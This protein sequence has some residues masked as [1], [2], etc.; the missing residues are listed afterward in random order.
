MLFNSFDFLVFFP[1]VVIAYF[2]CPHRRRWILL[3]FASYFFYMCWN[4]AYL[5][6]IVAS[7]AASYL[8][9]RLMADAPPTKRRVLLVAAIV[10]NLGMLFAFKYLGFAFGTLQSMLAVLNVAVRL[11]DLRFLLPI[12]ISFYTFQALSYC[13]DVYRGDMQPEKH[14]GVF[15]VYVSF[16]PQLVA[17][18]IERSTRLLPQFYRKHTFSYDKA[19]SGLRLMLWG[20]FKKMVIADRIAVYVDAVYGNPEAHFG[21]TV[22]IAAYLF[23]YQIYCDFSAYSD[24]AVGAARIMG[25]DLMTN[26]RRPYHASSVRDFW[27]RWHISLSTWFRDYLYVPLGGNRLS[28][29]KW[30]RNIAVVFLL[31]GLWHGAA[32]NFVVWG[33]LHGLYLV[34]WEAAGKRLKSKTDGSGG[35]ISSWWQRSLGVFVTFHLVTF[36][37][38]FFRAETLS[39]AS[40]LIRNLLRWGHTTF[41]QSVCIVPGR[42]WLAEVFCAIVLVE[43]VHL[44]QA[45]KKGS[46]AWVLRW[47]RPVRWAV[48][49]ALVMWIVF[50][51]VVGHSPFIYFQF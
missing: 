9:G 35:A 12:G 33:A 17:G 32:W 26:F 45:L 21:P 29:G 30:V 43:G 31:S 44:L 18:P 8:C 50:L 23:A 51:G 41:A 37:W 27:G 5:V 14:F 13:I 20:F 7:T 3:L 11:P 34:G 10:A 38:I 42:A 2:V 6:L 46:V 25:Y 28:K 36:A 40:L 39:D 16:F 48:Y 22:A 24:I 1:A 19:T 4:P 15:A 49:Y 47:P